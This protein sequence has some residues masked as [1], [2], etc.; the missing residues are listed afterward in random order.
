MPRR[1]DHYNLQLFVTAAEE[2]SI[3]RAAAKENI[4]PSALSR[5]IADLE[6]AFGLPLFVRSAHGIA[7]TE[8]GQV[9]HERARHLESG[10]ESLIRDVQCLSGVVS[11]QVRLVANASSVIGFLPERLKSFSAEYPRVSIALEERLSREVLRACL[12]D[13]ADV[14]VAVVESVPSGLDSWHFADDPLMVVLPRDHPLSV[15]EA[16]AFR[17]VVEYPLVGIQ[18]GGALDR[19]LRDRAAAARLELHVAVTVN[20]FDAVCRMVEAGLGIAV[21]PRSAAAAY[22]GSNQF[23]RRPLAEPWVGRELRLIAMRKNPRSPA[24]AALIDVLKR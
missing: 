11:G 1:F 15:Q 8:A 10:L 21:V 3:A 17:E 18:T 14:G 20:S 23:E 16:V 12:D 19:T 22:A 9:A 5:R 24:V 6:H 7:L 4:A 2:G 13:V